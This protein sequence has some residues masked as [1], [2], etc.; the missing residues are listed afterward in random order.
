MPRRLASYLGQSAWPARGWR[1][2]CRA[3]SLAS[4]ARQSGAPRTEK[5]IAHRVQIH[6]YSTYF[7]SSTSRAPHFFSL[8]LCFRPTFL[9]KGK[10]SYLQYDG[11]WYI[12][13]CE[14]YLRFFRDSIPYGLQSRFKFGQ[15]RGD[16]INNMIQQ[17]LWQW[18]W[19]T[20][21]F[22]LSWNTFYL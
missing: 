4:S 7:W 8:P 12:T 10:M 1:A 14:R 6:M 17:C 15:I 13:Y 21:K 11:T 20:L 3:R 2:R 22:K 18:W 9:K 19:F 16:S 5:G